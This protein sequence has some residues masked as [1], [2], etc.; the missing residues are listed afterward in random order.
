[1]STLTRQVSVVIPAF[2]AQRT[3]EKTLKSVLCQDYPTIEVILV[4]DGSTD[5]TSTVAR[6]VLSNY[7]HV[8]SK[9]INQPNRGVSAARNRGIRESSG[10]YVALLDSDDCWTQG[11]LAAQAGTLDGDDS[12]VAVT[13]SY[14]TVD[15]SGKALGRRKHPKWTTDYALD[16]LALLAP[17]P[18]IT[19]TGLL[20]RSAL[21]GCGLFDEGLSTAADAEFGYRLSKYGGIVTL[22]SETVLYRQSPEQMH[23]QSD[24]VTRDYETLLSMA[25]LQTDSFWSRSCK[26]LLAYRGLGEISDKYS[27][28]NARLSLMIR[29]PQVFGRRAYRN[30]EAIA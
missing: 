28:T 15:E 4:D 6:S 24:A 1:L 22:R 26:V 25:P 7:P 11:K 29:H 5:Q 14:Q 3:I 12:L 13:T 18:L 20:R 30:L 23:R 19:S 8:A 16:W 27:R 21:D 2:N 17:G 10:N 9:V